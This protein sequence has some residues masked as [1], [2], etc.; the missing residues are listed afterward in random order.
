[1]SNRRSF[2]VKSS[3]TAAVVSLDA[4]LV[5]CGGGNTTKPSQ[6]TYGIASGDPLADR[7]ILWT[8]A[9]IPDSTTPVALTWQ[10]CVDMSFAA[11]KVVSTGTLVTDASTGFT[12]KVDATGLTPGTSYY[13]RFVDGAG[14]SSAVGITRTLPAA[15]ASSVKLAVFSCSLYS[16]GYFNVY[17]AA[18]ASDAQ[19][20]I[21]LGDYIYEYGVG[22]FGDASGTTGRAAP[23][24]A[25]DI[26][27]LSDYRARY[28]QY[29]SDP[30]LQALHAKMPWI[31]VWDDHEFANNAFVTGAQNH[32][33]SQGDWTVRKNN[34]ATAYHEWMPIRTDSSNLLKIYRSFDFGGL[35]SLHMLDT[36][37]EGRV[38]QYGYFGDPANAD[39]S[40]YNYAD[41]VGGI[42]TGSDANRTMISKTQMDWLTGRFNASTAP[43]QILGNQDIMGRMWFPASVLGA[44]AAKGATVDSI[45]QAVGAY[46]TAKA[47]PAAARS[48]EQAG[49]ANPLVNPRLPYNLDSWDGYPLQR[50]GIL[51]T[52]S[53]M[54]KNLIAIS[55]DSHNAWFNNL[56]LLDGTKVGYE[57]AGSS[58]TSPGFESVGLGAFAPFVDG[59]YV[60]KSYGS[61]MGL[62]D[63]VNYSDTSRRGY[64]LLTVTPTTV[65]GDYVFVDTIGSTKYT[66]TT[67]KSITVNV[68]RSVIYA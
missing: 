1:M 4:A 41:Y 23:S 18:L 38:Q 20:A 9:K 13:Y 15:N 55:G 66:A 22:G 28:A 48:P 5:A 51:R 7:V 8:Y 24:P 21:H 10:V 60:T 68:D 19:Y 62:V 58:V 11:G 61:G 54:K 37:I 67:G 63:D 35:L 17:D 47:T 59:S 25:K 64:L 45:S 57:F 56:S 32:N 33:A 26:V 46:I 50:E 29:R 31:T 16:T 12:G 3:A 27:T 52:A 36:R 65:K 2:L 42:Q 40:A 14:V 34:A 30:N 39:G 43:W 49:L 44:Q 53:A 6:F